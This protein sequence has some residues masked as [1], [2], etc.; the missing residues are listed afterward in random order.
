ML[1]RRIFA[2]TTLQAMKTLMFKYIS[3]LESL[4]FQSLERI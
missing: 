2:T 4:T 3:I 1:H